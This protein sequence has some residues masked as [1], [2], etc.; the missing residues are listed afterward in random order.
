VQVINNWTDHAAIA[1]SVTVN[2]VA[3]QQVPVRLEYYEKGGNAVI[4]LRWLTPGNSTYVTI[5]ATQLT[6]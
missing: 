3:G 2:L 4:Q 6:P 5:P 1:N